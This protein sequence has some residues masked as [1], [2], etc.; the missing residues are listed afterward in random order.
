MK[1][2]IDISP[3]ETGHNV[4]GVGFYLQNLKASLEQVKSENKY[5]FFSEA[6][7]IPLDASVIHF[8]YFDPFFRTLP[9]KKKYPTVVTVHDLIPLIFP[10]HFPSG[11]RGKL[12]WQLQKYLLE[13]VDMVVTD[14]E[15]SKRDIHRLLAIPDGKVKVVYLAASPVYIHQNNSSHQKMVKEKYHL[16]DKFVLYVGDVTWNKNLVRLIKSIK[17]LGIPLVMVGKALASTNYD[18]ENPWNA[19]LVTIQQE[20]QHNPLFTI[21][22]F[23]PTDDLIT[24]YNLATVFTMPSLYEG[25]GLPVLEAMQCGTPVVST[26][27]GSLKEIAGDAAEI[28]EANDVDSIVCG[29]KKV[30]GSEHY[31][32][33]LIEKGF[34]HAKK[35]SW[36]KTASDMISIYEH[37]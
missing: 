35:F 9:V 32:K 14:S 18:K 1:I 11:I 3:L 29:I 24:I 19:D 22:G 4:R 20:T 25:F 7:N 2:A 27:G 33:L 34:V 31:Q 13:R 21:L 17:K 16:P 37:V 5:I 26:H 6:K 36:E 15:A 28:V 30:Y 12:V 8:P 10:E 23:I